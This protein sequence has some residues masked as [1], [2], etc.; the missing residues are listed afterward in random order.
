MFLHLWCSHG[1]SYLKFFIQVYNCSDM[2]K[3]WCGIFIHILMLKGWSSVHR[4]CHQIFTKNSICY[5][6]LAT[7]V[8]T[9]GGSVHKLN[10]DVIYLTKSNAI[11]LTADDTTTYITT[12]WMHLKNGSQFCW[13]ETWKYVTFSIVIKPLR[14]SVETN[15]TDSHVSSNNSGWTMLK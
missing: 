2:A 14:L 1:E 4:M 12:W 5:T 6:N 9:S 15:P 10:N 8:M 13:Q 3:T 7:F 11:L